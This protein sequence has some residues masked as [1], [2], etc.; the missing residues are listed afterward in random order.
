MCMG[1]READRWAYIVTTYRVKRSDSRENFSNNS[2]LKSSTHLYAICYIFL[3]LFFP[4]DLGF[5]ENYIQH[6]RKI[7]LKDH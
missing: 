6:E 5:Y 4:H 1:E 7:T 2:N 3:L